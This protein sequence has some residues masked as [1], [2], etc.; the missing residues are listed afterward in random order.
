M[1]YDNYCNWIIRRSTRVVGVPATLVGTLRTHGK[2]SS[3]MGMKT[4]PIHMCLTPNSIFYRISIAA[5]HIS[6]LDS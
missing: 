2:K 6:Y 4:L 3:S 5:I 1:I